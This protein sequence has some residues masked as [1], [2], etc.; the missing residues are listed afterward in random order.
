MKEKIDITTVGETKQTFLEAEMTEATKVKVGGMQLTAGGI[1]E[2]NIGEIGPLKDGDWLK[3]EMDSGAQ[4][5]EV[6]VWRANG[7]IELDDRPGRNSDPTPIDAADVTW[8]PVKSKEPIGMI[9][10]PSIQ[11]SG[12]YIEDADPTPEPDPVEPDYLY[13]TPVDHDFMASPLIPFALGVLTASI[14]WFIIGLIN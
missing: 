3:I 14:A 13:D 8:D 7:E 5:V 2:Y 6:E 11:A 1:V 4:E 12:R 10:P 9:D